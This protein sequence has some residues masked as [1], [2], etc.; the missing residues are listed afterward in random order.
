MTERLTLPYRPDIDGLRAIAVSIVV[1]FHAFPGFLPGGFVGV[2][3]FFVIS[4]FLIT[5]IILG[6]LRSGDFSFAEFYARRIRRI[7]PALVVVLAASQVMGWWW[8]YPDDFASL[9]RHV[10]AGAAFSSNFLLWRE[11]NYFDTA[12]DLRPLLHLW[13]LGIE[14]QFYLVWP[15][16][17]VWAYRWRRGPLALTLTI[18]SA[19]F[20]AAIYTVRT[21]PTAAFYAPWHRFWELLAGATLACLQAEGRL[22]L[23]PKITGALAVVGFGAIGVGALVIDSSRVFPGLWAL[24]PVAGTGL[25]IIAGPRTVINRVVLASPALVGLGLISYPLYLWH[26]PL[27]AFTRITTD[28]QPP[29]HVLITVI[30]LSVLLAWATYRLV[31]S[32]IRFGP[33]RR[34]ATAGLSAAMVLVAGAGLATQQ[35]QGFDSRAVV[36]RDEGQFVARYERMKKSGIAGAYRSECD[37]MEWGTSANRS[38]LDPGCTMP[39]SKRTFFLWGDSFAQALSLGIRDVL[40]PGI[41]L[42]QVATSGCRPATEHYDEPGVGVRCDQSNAF[43]AASIRQLR[44]AVV[45]LAQ[46]QKHLA[47]DW[48]ALSKRI[49]ELGV[50]EVMVVGPA[51]IWR[52]TLPVVFARNYLASPKEYVADGLDP[53]SFSQDQQLS[54]EL[55]NTSGLTYVSLVARLCQRDGCRATVPGGAPTDLMAFDFGHLTPQGSIYVGREVFKPYLDRVAR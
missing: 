12:A 50:G 38:T 34:F 42:A 35:A 5:G 46:S 31:E 30:A 43:A 1:A 2:D 23:S 8:L 40:P 9:G 24:L 33:R 20:V 54:A 4:G 22:R 53:D 49:H 51:P 16:L 45:V 21:D 52:P 17:L 37:F 11:L 3:V 32:P 26:W 18:A 29:A 28:G 44:P 13:S 55:T 41:S 14:E 19:S 47:T 10:A 39:G 15:L 48:L 7:F 6:A 25:L 36:L 27:L